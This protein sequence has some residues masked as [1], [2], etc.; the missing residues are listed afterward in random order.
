[1]KLFIWKYAS[2]IVFSLAENEVQA[3]EMILKDKDSWLRD[4][5]ENGE[6][7]VFDKPCYFNESLYDG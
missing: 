1:M 6:L 2:S 3:R 5:I 4:V 7:Q